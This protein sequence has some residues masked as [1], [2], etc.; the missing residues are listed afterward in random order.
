VVGV[1][2]FTC[3]SEMARREGMCTTLLMFTGLTFATI[4]T[5]AAR[6][7]RGE[8]LDLGELPADT[9]GQPIEVAP[10]RETGGGP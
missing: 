8:N 1:G 5:P 3:S 6:P 7:A 2:P 4:P 9:N 10:V